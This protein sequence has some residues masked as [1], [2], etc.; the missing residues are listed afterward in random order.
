M[1]L[2]N[3]VN[4]TFDEIEVSNHNIT[5]LVGFN[6]RL[7]FDRL[8]TFVNNSGIY[9]GGIALYEFSQLSLVKEHINISFV[10]NHASESGGGIFVSPVVGVDI[11]T[12]CSFILNNSYYNSSAV[13]YFVN[14]TADISGDILYGGNVDKCLNEDEFNN[15]FPLPQTKWSISSVIRPSSSVLLQIRNTKLLCY[16]H[17]YNCNTWG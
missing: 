10:D 14:N 15:L 5:G 4:V 2:F 7:T 8:S 12:K 9:G 6:S 13:L 3:V 17:Q 16:K 1:V 11:S